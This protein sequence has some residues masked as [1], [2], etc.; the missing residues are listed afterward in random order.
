M[1]MPY[2][3]P[4]VWHTY[5]IQGVPLHLQDVFGQPID[6]AEEEI[7][8]RPLP[9]LDDIR[10][11]SGPLNTGQT[12]RHTGSPGLC[13]SGT[14]SPLSVFSGPASRPT[15]LSRRPRSRGMI[16]D[17]KATAILDT[18]LAMAGAATAVKESTSTKVPLAEN[19][20]MPRIVPTAMAH[21]QPITGIA[22]QHL[23]GRTARS[24]SSP[25]RN[26]APYERLGI[27]CIEIQSPGGRL[28]RPPPK[29][30][31]QEIG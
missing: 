30:Q 6:I 14:Q 21:S 3:F 12:S 29:S 5:A 24:S 10:S 9:R 18:A 28:S 8:L 19:A 25:G 31:A 1:A 4:E 16:L 20:S 11:V 15:L 2:V 27:D 13:L 17:V 23:T 22:Q 26:S 7:A